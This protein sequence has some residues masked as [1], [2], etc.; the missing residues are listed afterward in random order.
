[1][2]C[3]LKT[4]GRLYD[5]IM[6]VRMNDRDM[7][8]NVEGWGEYKVEIKFDGLLYVRSKEKLECLGYSQYWSNCFRVGNNMP[9]IDVFSVDRIVHSE[10]LEFRAMMQERSLEVVRECRKLRMLERNRLATQRLRQGKID[11]IV[12]LERKLADKVKEGGEILEKERQAV[13]IRDG[14]R[15]EQDQLIEEIV[16]SLGLDKEIYT[17]NM[18]SGKVVVV[19]RVVEPVFRTWGHELG[20]DFFRE[21]DVPELAELIEQYDI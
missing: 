12:D 10:I 20:E 16:C 9:S 6:C 2:K 17:I 18:D 11:L 13:E 14:L 19:R 8:L 1:M 15:R 3:V 4:Y 7:K 21:G 5:M